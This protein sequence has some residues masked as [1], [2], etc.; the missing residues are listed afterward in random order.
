[1][2]GPGISQTTTVTEQNVFGNQTEVVFTPA[3]VYAPGT[4]IFTPP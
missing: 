4:Y 2:T 3:F 1:M